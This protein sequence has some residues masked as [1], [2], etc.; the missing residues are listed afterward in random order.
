MRLDDSQFNVPEKLTPEKSQNCYDI[1]VEI[2]EKVQIKF[3]K[4]K[5]EIKTEDK[6]SNKTKGL[7]LRREELRRK[8]RKKHREKIELVELYKL[9]KKEIRNDIKAYNHQKIKDI[10]EDNGSTKK[11]RRDL[12][13]ERRFMANLKDNKGK[14][15]VNRD[16]IVEVVTKFYEDLYKKES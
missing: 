13:E 8:P 16:E 2:M 12:K 11:M 14:M 1:F 15:R 9:T 3:G 10:I 4:K 6:L 5:D 7:I